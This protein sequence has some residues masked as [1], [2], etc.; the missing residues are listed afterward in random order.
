MSRR[1][2]LPAAFFS[3]MGTPVRN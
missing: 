3:A 1:H 2:P